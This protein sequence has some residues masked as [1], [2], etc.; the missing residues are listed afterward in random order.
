MANVKVMHGSSIKGLKKLNKVFVALSEQSRKKSGRFGFNVNLAVGFA[1]P[2]HVYVHEN[3]QYAHGAAYNAK[4]ADRIQRGLDH[5]RR[6][7]EQAKYLEQPAR[8]M[9]GQLAALIRNSMKN[10]G[11]LKEV[12]MMAG[13]ALMRAAQHLVPIDTGELSNSGFVRLK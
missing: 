3:L 2:Y 10:G 7:Q 8:E 5:K 6:P 11:E 4:Y 12:L 1:A 13:Y 9:R